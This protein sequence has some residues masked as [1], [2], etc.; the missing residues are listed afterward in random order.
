MASIT[1]RNGRWRV[2]V[3]RAGVD[4]CATF[5]SRAAAKQW[6]TRIESEVDELRASGILQPRGLTVG[7]LIARYIEELYPTKKW[8]RSKTADLARL[9]KE[10]GTVAVDKLNAAHV[11]KVFR[12]RHD[13][14][15]GPVTVS[16]Q[17]GYLVG[18]LKVAR[19]LWHLDVPLQAAQ[20][21]RAALAHVGLI[22]KG[23]RRDRRVTDSEI[24]AILK[25][26]D[27]R[28]TTIPYGDLVRFALA[29]G[30]RISEICRLE[31]RDVDNAKKTVVIRDRKH[32]QDKLGNDQV[33][34][35]LNE[36]GYDAFEIALRQPRGAK[37]I[38]PY[39]EKTVC[40][41]FPRAMKKLGIE[42]LHFHDLRHEAIS[43]LFE[44]GYRIEQV[45]LVSGHRD[46]AMLKRYT[47]VRAAD[48][49][50]TPKPVA[51]A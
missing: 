10:L 33:V 32:P 29:T 46:W 41:T 19:S 18:V 26:Y 51:T 48:L 30:M 21:A 11:V 8:G 6:A 3:R 5:G 16:A 15:A 28:T 23:Q 42:D 4:K 36:T 12:D 43:R 9:K 2:L 24:A 34:P 31:W 17:C 1:E 44:A 14:G 7:D 49:H 13:E 35:M 39:R 47:H 25:F 38:F 37:R 50:R 40:S 22:G 20:D 45:A 27:A